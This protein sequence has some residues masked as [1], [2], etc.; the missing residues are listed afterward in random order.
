MIEAT[1]G[2]IYVCLN[3]R[4]DGISICGSLDDAYFYDLP[5]I[6]RVVDMR[7]Y[8]INP[9]PDYLILHEISDHKT[10]CELKADI[11]SDFSLT[12]RLYKIDTEYGY[13]D[14]IVGFSVGFDELLKIAIHALK[15]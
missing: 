9:S 7:V 15:S 11:I 3:K 1:E 12:L 6:F 5:S 14:S 13:E 4:L 8:N 10:E 2:V